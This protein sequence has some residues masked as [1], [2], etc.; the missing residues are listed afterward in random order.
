[1]YKKFQGAHSHTASNTRKQGGRQRLLLRLQRL[2][3]LLLLL[4]ERKVHSNP[5]LEAIWPLQKHATKGKY[6]VLLDSIDA[7]LPPFQ[8]QSRRNLSCANPSEKLKALR[9]R[10]RRT[11]DRAAIEVVGFFSQKKEDERKCPYVTMIDVPCLD[12]RRLFDALDEQRWL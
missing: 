4:L 6:L 3:L 2:L 7:Q 11:K 12:V 1:M 10:R 5:H 8:P 9:R